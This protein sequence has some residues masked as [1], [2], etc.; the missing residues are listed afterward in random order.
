M[1]EDPIT[2]GTEPIQNDDLYA[3][4]QER[5][6]WWGSRREFR[7]DRVV[8][9]QAGFDAGRYEFTYLLKVVAPGVFRASP[10]RIAAMYVPDG[11]AS[12]AAVGL[13]V[14]GPPVPAA[15]APPK[16]GRQ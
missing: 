15:E 12:S 13:T 3:L 10:A 6:A 11:T 4:E 5:G 8:F 9:F 7:D 2:A 14:A 16:G 1:I